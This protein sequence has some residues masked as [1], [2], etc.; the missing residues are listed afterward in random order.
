MPR[1]L[2]RV[3]ARFVALV[4]ADFAG[5]RAGFIA[6][7]IS[8]GGDL[9][10]GIT[11]GAITNTLTALPGLIVLVPA[12]IGMRG[13]VFGALGSRLGTMIHAGTFRLSARVDTEVGQNMAAAMLS[14]ISIAA[15]LAVLA[16]VM[17]ETF[18][19]GPSISVLDFLVISVIGA[20]ISSVV[21]LAITVAVAAFCARRSLALDNVAA[22]IVTASG[23]MVTLP[24]LFLATYLVGYD[25]VTPVVG[26]LC[27]VLA[28]G[29]AVVGLR[30]RGLPLLQR[31]VLESLP[32]LAL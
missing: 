12:A 32:I 9:V 23:D 2:R 27:L 18:G 8:S 14:S 6:L 31:I 11:L 4:R 1:L 10:T 5:V 16:K 3:G 19:H 30:A 13:N 21:V 28:L 26:V 25:I 20:L 17:F 24:S 7:L 29:C 15:L 22:P